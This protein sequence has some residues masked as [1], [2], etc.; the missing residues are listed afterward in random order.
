MYVSKILD[1][2]VNG[3][4]LDGGHFAS[5]MRRATISYSSNPVKSE[6][7]STSVYIKCMPSEEKAL[8]LMENI[9]MFETEIKMYSETICA[10]DRLLESLGEKFRFAPE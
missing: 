1:L 7:K 9:P 4:S 8:K 2:K 6:E 3:G 10:M 5:S